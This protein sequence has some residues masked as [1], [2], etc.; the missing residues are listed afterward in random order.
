MPRKVRCTACGFIMQEGKLGDR[1]PACGALRKAF[2]PYEDPLSEERR[3]VL[4]RDF[5][6]IAVHFP[7]AFAVSL[8]VLSISPFVLSGPIEQ[9]SLSTAKLLSPLL[10]LLVIVAFLA[11]VADG[12]VRFRR[13]DRSLILKQKVLYG[14]LFFLFSVGLSL[15]VWFGGLTNPLYAALAIFLSTATV[16][17]SLMLGLLGKS[18]LNSAFPG[19]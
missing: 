14:L 6:P 7:I 5:H 8:V 9:L 11:G 2:E 12:K 15:V 19:K 10:P 1:C 16:F 13:I 3:R 17:F 18:I 4:D